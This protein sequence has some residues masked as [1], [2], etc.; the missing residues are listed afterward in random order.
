MSGVERV[1]ESVSPEL[2]Q[3]SFEIG[4]R[5]GG[6]W[7]RWNGSATVKEANK[8]ILSQSL[9][10]YGSPRIA[11]IRSRSGGVRGAH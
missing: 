7:W 10:A 3:K 9:M 11:V 6:V 1:R 8:A 4:R 2:A 5:R